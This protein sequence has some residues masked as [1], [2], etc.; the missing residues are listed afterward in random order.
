MDH[1]YPIGK[2]EPKEYSDCSGQIENKQHR[3]ICLLT[4]MCLY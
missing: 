1:R 2:Y 4:V 3:N